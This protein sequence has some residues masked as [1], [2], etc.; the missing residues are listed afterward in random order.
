MTTLV[1][2]A[3]I[4]DNDDMSIQTEHNPISLDCSALAD[5]SQP[6][7]KREPLLAAF[8]TRLL[9]PDSTPPTLLATLL[10]ER[11]VSRSI[12]A[13]TLHEA[14]LRCF[15]QPALAAAAAA[16][17]EAI[18]QRDSACHS[19]LSALLFSKG[20]LALQG[21]RVAHNLWLGGQRNAA[22]LLQH[23]IS[24]QLGV[25]IHPAAVI[26]GGV[27]LDHATGVVIGETARVGDNVS[28]MQGVT[29]GGTGKE[30]GD[31][32]PKVGR[33][34]LLGPGAKVLGNIDIGCG[35]MV[36]AAAVV[37]KSVSANTVVAG[38]PAQPVGRTDN[39]NP[40]ELMDHYFQSAE[41]QNRKRRG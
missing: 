1:P 18:F 5:E 27:M 28:I 25:D 14:A 30:S 11:I 2:S 22:L 13:P 35:A 16:D 21:Y 31:R 36:A 32:H 8:I 38:V 3:V 40:A 34:V 19:R 39:D 20:F 15:N 7:C 12:D 37:L 33:G 4:V 10:S 24:C 29:L 41:Q 6:L 9:P 26:G 23:T 17:L